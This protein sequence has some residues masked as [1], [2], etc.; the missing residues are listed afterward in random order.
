[1][2]MEQLMSNNAFLQSRAAIN[3]HLLSL[4]FEQ[5]EKLQVNHVR[6]PTCRAVLCEIV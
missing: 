2:Q 5:L 4:R 6:G 1:M 3:R